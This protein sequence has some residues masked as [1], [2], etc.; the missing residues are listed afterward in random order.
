MCS[1]L[2]AATASALVFPAYFSYQKNVQNV[3]WAQILSACTWFAGN[4]VAKWPN[5][6]SQG[7]FTL[8]SHQAAA[9]A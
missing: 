3:F 7:M 9:Y 1:R 6:L 5:K 2:P 8:G 4:T